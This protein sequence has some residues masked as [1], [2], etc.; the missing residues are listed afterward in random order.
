MSIAFRIIKRISAALLALLMIFIVGFFIWRIISSSNSKSMETLIPSSALC[1]LYER[2]GENMYM[3]R[4]EQRSITSSEKN[5]GYFTVTDCVF[6][7]DANTVQATLRYNNS[8]L[9]STAEDYSL[10]SVPDRGSEVY[11]M[12]LL[13]AIDLTP[14]DTE[15]N[16]GNDEGSVRFVRVKGSVALTEQKNL[17]NFRRMVFELGDAELDMRKML[18]DGTLLAVY[19]DI[20]Y[21]GDIDY[22]KEAYGTLCLYDYKTEKISVSLTKNDIAALEAFN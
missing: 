18:D 20:Y 21:V 7:P 17:Y 3:F 4:Q 1:E 12:S 19:A 16:L 14:E 15:D 10:P 13:F 5:Y 8:T 11:E 9:R 2:D 22:G 6:I